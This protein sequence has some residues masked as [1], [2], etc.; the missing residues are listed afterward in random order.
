MLCGAVQLVDEAVACISSF[1]C[2]QTDRRSDE[3]R[4]RVFGVANIFPAKYMP[5]KIDEILQ[6]GF[7]IVPDLQCVIIPPAYLQGV[8]CGL[9]RLLHA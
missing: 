4:N 5:N 2:Q 8:G 1:L 7:E 9:P 6:G 3:S